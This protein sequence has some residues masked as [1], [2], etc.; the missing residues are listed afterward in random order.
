MLGVLLLFAASHSVS[1]FVLAGEHVEFAP[2]MTPRFTENQIRNTAAATREGLARWARTEEGRKI[3]AFFR[4]SEYEIDVVEYGENKAVGRAPQPGIAT[5]AAANDHQKRKT[6]ELILNPAF[7]KMPDG[8]H[9]LLNE[10]ANASDMMA[11]AWAG[12]MLH[13]YFYA[14]GISLPHHPRSDFQDEWR[15]V[16]AELGMPLVMHDD[17]DRSRFMD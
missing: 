12:E 3:I 10:P 9:A 15:K 5:L 1:A 14:Q 7:F 16:A 6:Y 17:E 13:I 11:I 8:M 2:D 4:S